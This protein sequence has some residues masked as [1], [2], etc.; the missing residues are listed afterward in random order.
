MRNFKDAADIRKYSLDQA[1]RLLEVA[2]GA[3][4]TSK[5]RDDL[6]E[7]NMMLLKVME[8]NK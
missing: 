6:T 3:T 2:I 8:E 5:F 7:I 4:P 1:Q